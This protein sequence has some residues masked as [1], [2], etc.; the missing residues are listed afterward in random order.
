MLFFAE[1]SGNNRIEDRSSTQM[2]VLALVLVQAKDELDAGNKIQKYM[3]KNS[4]KERV[5]IDFYLDNWTHLFDCEII[6]VGAI[7]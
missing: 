5:M 7:I 1:I 2:V 4:T 3:S 6:K